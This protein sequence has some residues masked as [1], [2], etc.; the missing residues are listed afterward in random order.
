MSRQGDTITLA[1]AEEIIGAAD[2]NGRGM[3][4]FAEFSE[5]FAA[6]A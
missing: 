1:E 4:D 5:L 2:R 3:L 6:A